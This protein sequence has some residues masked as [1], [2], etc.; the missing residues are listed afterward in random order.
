MRSCGQGQCGALWMAEVPC[1]C[2]A[3]VECSALGSLE[4]GLL[5]SFAGFLA[6][7]PVLLP[8]KWRTPVQGS[9]HAMH[10]EGRA[11]QC[12]FNRGCGVLNARPLTEQGKQLKMSHCRRDTTC[13][14][15]KGDLLRIRKLQKCKY[16]QKAIWRARL[17]QSGRGKASPPWQRLHS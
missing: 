17:V 7:A 5:G 1:Q 9:S 13:M 12:F 14:I 10:V 15:G 11:A 16:L 2:L 4:C 8:A 3:D 6:L